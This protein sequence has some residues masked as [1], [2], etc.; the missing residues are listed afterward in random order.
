M[1]RTGGPHQRLLNALG[2]DS[3]RDLLQS[4]DAVKSW[5]PPSSH[6]VKQAT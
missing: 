2:P 4:L 6:S 3:E 1:D 5:T